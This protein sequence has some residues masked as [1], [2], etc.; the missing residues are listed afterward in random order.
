MRKGVV[1]HDVSSFD[2]L[3]YD[4]R[5]LLHIASDQKKSC[6]NFVFGED[7]QQTQGVRIVWPI[8]VGERD[9]L[10]ATWQAG[11]RAPMPLSHRRHGLITRGSKRGGDSRPGEHGSE[12]GRIVIVD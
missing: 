10:G 6:A 2:D 7:L 9:L 5:P 12:H 3:P 4:F 11:E 8:V 1:A